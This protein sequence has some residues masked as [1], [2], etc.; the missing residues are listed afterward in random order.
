MSHEPET[1][2]SEPET[3]PLPVEKPPLCRFIRHNGM[4]IYTSAPPP[5]EDDPKYDTTIFW[6]SKTTT[7]WGPDDGEVALRDCRNAERTC[8]EPL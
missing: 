2:A 3:S 1:G 8:Y 6:C 4:L 5:D 7:G